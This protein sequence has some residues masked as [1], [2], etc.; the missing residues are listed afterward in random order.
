MRLKVLNI[1]LNFYG[2]LKLRV[3]KYLTNECID[4][5][6]VRTGWNV[7]LNKKSRCV[8]Q[9]T[10]ETLLQRNAKM[11][12][13]NFFSLSSIEDTAEGLYRASLQKELRKIH[14][15]SDAIISRLE[16]AKLLK[17]ISTKGVD[18]H[19]SECQ[20]IDIPY[21]EPR[22]RVNDLNNQLS[23]ELLGIKYSN[24]KKIIKEKILYLDQNF[25][26]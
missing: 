4:F 15:C 1:H 5:T 22:G 2:E 8:I 25:L 20:F 12:V 24:A 21:S 3:E 6:I 19:F 16:M 9:L 13:D 11:A 26:F 7:G 14:I 17:N 10:Y 18:M 23:K